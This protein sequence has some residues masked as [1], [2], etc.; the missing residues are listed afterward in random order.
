MNT[1]SKMHKKAL[2]HLERAISLQF[3]GPGRTDH[4][5]PVNL[6]DALNANDISHDDLTAVM[7]K[8]NDMLVKLNINYQTHQVTD[9]NRFLELK[10]SLNQLMNV[11]NLAKHV[12][13]QLCLDANGDSINLINIRTETPIQWGT[14][15][16]IVD[17][18]QENQPY[19]DDDPFFY[20]SA[21]VHRNTRDWYGR[22]H[23]D[24]N[25][26]SYQDNL[27]AIALAS[28]YVFSDWTQDWNSDKNAGDLL[29]LA[30]SLQEHI[31][32]QYASHKQNKDEV[33]S[34]MRVLGDIDNNLRGILGNK[35]TRHQ[36]DQAIAGIADLNK[37][38]SH[39]L[40]TSKLSHIRHSKP[41]TPTGLLQIPQMPQNSHFMQL[42]VKTPN[43]ENGV[44]V[45]HHLSLQHDH[46]PH[47]FVRSTNTITN[48]D[49]FELHSFFT[50]QEY[51]RIRRPVSLSDFQRLFY[52]Y[53]FIRVYDEL[54]PNRNDRLNEFL[55]RLKWIVHV[56]YPNISTNA[57]LCFI[58]KLITSH[59]QFVNYLDL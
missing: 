38:L 28:G 17:Q 24:T 40:H 9:F 37:V 53:Y 49:S 10:Q 14:L 32:T 55:E 15:E 26:R 58:P 33:T 43:C 47:A 12:S 27:Q 34:H 29:Q 31:A 56:L 6:R 23:E 35:V 3:G 4:F 16:M 41:A 51:N 22:S 7:D 1:E 8:F 48:S 2:H 18:I 30:V 5:F 20:E 52:S 39:Q 45:L 19:R 36:Y 46:N 42:C 59:Y 11:R 44:A 21:P 13:E 25:L 57:E 50:S 54:D